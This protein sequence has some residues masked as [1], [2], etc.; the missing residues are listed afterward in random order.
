[1][2]R[3]FLELA[4]ITTVVMVVGLLAPTEV[5]AQ[6]GHG[7]TILKT[8][9]EQVRT[10]TS[11]ADC[12]DNNACNGLETCDTSISATTVCHITVANADTFGDTLTVKNAFDVIKPNTAGFVTI[13]DLVVESV[14][15]NTT[16]AVGDQPL[17][18]D[19]TTW[20]D[21]GPD[22]GAGEGSVT[23]ISNSYV[24]KPGID[25]NPLPDQG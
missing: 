21:I 14:A 10:C 22:V 3:R 20:C 12:S 9:T 7:V 8:C 1:M 6:A 19:P 24:P 15:G 25:P 16:C 18:L 5:M 11:D 17:L 13:P 4:V 23:F 2:C